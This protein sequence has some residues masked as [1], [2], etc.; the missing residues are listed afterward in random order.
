MRLGASLRWL[1]YPSGFSPTLADSLP[2]WTKIFWPSAPSIDCLHRYLGL[3][4]GDHDS[5]TSLYTWSESHSVFEM[6]SADL[7]MLIVAI[8]VIG[9][10]WLYVWLNKR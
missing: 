2:F 7:T 5:P 3:P 10:F 6:N 9:L 1:G 4:F 8:V